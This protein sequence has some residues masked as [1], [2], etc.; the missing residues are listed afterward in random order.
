[1]FSSVSSIL[2]IP[3]ACQG[4]IDLQIYCRENVFSKKTIVDQKERE[5]RYFWVF[6]FDLYVKD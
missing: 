3:M 4:G 2:P 6:L 1:M 5:R